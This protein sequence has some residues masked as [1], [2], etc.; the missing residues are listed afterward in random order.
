MS[1]SGNAGKRRRVSSTIVLDAS[2]LLA[3]LRDELGA[4]TV[5][6]A[7]TSEAVISSVNWA[8]VLSKG[9]EEGENPEETVAWLETQGILG[10]WLKVIPLIEADAINIARLRPLTKAQGLSLGDRACLAL[11]LRLGLPVLTADQIWTGLDLRVTV[12]TIR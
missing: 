8:E 11:G 7:I 3:Y 12:Q 6:G 10:R 5:S 9:A 4:E 2:A 1:L